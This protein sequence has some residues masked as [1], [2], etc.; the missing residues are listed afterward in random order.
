MKNKSIL[1]TI[2]VAL[3]VGAT[4]FYG[5]M[6]YQQKQR[7]NFAGGQFR[8]LNGQQVQGRG[9]FQGTRPVNGEI[10][11]QDDKSITVKMQDGS[12]KIVILSD[13]TIINKASEGSKEDLKTGEKV[14]AFGTENSDGS[15]TAQNISI[16]GMMLRGLQE[17]QSTAK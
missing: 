4:A 9:N 11:S 13:Q 8:S 1:I 15:V 6:Q 5:G 14:T 2:V 12:S 10:I 3:I 17:G 7:P 16:G